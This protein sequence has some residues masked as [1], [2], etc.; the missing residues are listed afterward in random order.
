MEILS[1]WQ[2]RERLCWSPPLVDGKAKMA[3]T[4][5]TNWIRSLLSKSMPFRTS[6]KSELQRVVEVVAVRE[7]IIL[8]ESLFIK[9]TRGVSGL[10]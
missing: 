5:A 1:Y 3:V 4:S 9:S 7:E 2:R 10:S 6:W 8:P